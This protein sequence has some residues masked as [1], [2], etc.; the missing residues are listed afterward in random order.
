M[1]SG[2]STLPNTHRNCRLYV[3]SYEYPFH[4]TKTYPYNFDPL[5][6][7]FLYS[8]TRVYRDIHYFFLIS[9]HK[10][11]LWVLVRTASEQV[12]TI[13]VLNRNIK[14]ISF[15]YLKIFQFLELKISIDLNRRVF[16]L[17]YP[18]TFVDEG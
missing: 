14:S 2:K 17:K 5:K 12:P 13:Y 11:R 10:H 7:H 16:I 8:K 1:C 3:L 6:P 15:F 4:I 18:K 9:A